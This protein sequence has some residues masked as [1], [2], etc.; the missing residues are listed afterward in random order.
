D[1]C[2]HLPGLRRPE[3]SQG[4][5]LGDPPQRRSSSANCPSRRV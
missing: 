3:R 1:C 2:L 5:L 4:S